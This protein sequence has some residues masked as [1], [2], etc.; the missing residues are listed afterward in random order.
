MSGEVN[1]SMLAMNVVNI[2]IME[3]LVCRNGVY[4]LTAFASIVKPSEVAPRSASPEIAESDTK[5]ETPEPLDVEAR[6]VVSIKCYVQSKSDVTAALLVRA[7]DVAGVM[8]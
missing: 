2:C 3:N 1:E 6:R 4:P 5:S 7:S 8:S